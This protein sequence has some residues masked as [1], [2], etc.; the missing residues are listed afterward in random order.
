MQV[1]FTAECIIVMNFNGF[2]SYLSNLKKNYM[3][4][5]LFNFRILFKPRGDF[6]K[7]WF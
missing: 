7:W 5:V 4:S 3:F 6:T 1:L 2:Q